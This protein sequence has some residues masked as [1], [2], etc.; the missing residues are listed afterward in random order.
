MTRSNETSI[1]NVFFSHDILFSLQTFKEL[2]F[3]CKLSSL[4]FQKIIFSHRCDDFYSFA[5]NKFIQTTYTPD[6]KSIVNTE[7]LLLDQLDENLLRIFSKP[8][9]SFDPWPHKLAKQLYKNCMNLGK[10]IRKLI[11]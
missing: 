4:T 7:S 8:L 10:F 2:N 1:I 9:N 11:C 6:E 3:I 5:C